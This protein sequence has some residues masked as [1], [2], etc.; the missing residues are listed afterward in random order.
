VWLRYELFNGNLDQSEFEASE[1][2]LSEFVGSH[3]NRRQ[4]KSLSLVSNN[5]LPPI[6]AAGLVRQVSAGV[7]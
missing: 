4:L 7:S 1:R 3:N 5:V 2:S 6:A